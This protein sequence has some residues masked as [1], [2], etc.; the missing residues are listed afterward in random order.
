VYDVADIFKFD[1]VVPVAFR[2]AGKNPR[3]PEREV[4][5]ACRDTFRQSHLLDKIIPTI[6]EVLAAGEMERPKAHDEA[7]EIAIPNK[8]G[9][10]DAGY[11]A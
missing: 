11:R 3:N 7:V 6:E 8:E 1:T 2:I 10:G 5:L 4:R 9:F